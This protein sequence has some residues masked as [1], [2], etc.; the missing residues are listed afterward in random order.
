MSMSCR[1]CGKNIDS[2]AARCK[3]CGAP[4]EEASAG[5]AADAEASDEALREGLALFRQNSIEAALSAFEKA[6]ALNPGNSNAMTNCGLC[7]ASL[8]KKEKAVESYRKALELDPRNTAALNN[9]AE[10]FSES[11]NHEEALRYYDRA[12]AVRS[13]D[14]MLWGNKGTCLIYL[15]RYE[16]A[17]AAAERA[18]SLNRESGT[19]WHIKALALD[20]LNRAEESCTAYEKFL[21][22]AN[23][24]NMED[25]ERAEHAKKRIAFLQG[26][27]ALTRA[28]ADRLIEEGK[29]A[30]DSDMERA[31]ECFH[32]VTVLAPSDG[33]GWAGKAQVLQA[34]GRGEEALP[35]YDM[36][37]AL[38]PG[39]AG[40]WHMKADCLESMS[41]LQEALACYDRALEV[42]P[43]F[44]NA[45]CD[46][47]HCLNRMDR[48][49]EALACFDKALEIDNRLHVAWFNKAEQQLKLGRMDDAKRSY[50]RFMA[51]VPPGNDRLLQHAQKRI[52]QL[53]AAAISESYDALVDRG[54]ELTG[55]GSFEEA[56]FC[57]EKAGRLNPYSGRLW[58]YEGI[59]EERLGRQERAR[60]LFQRAVDAFGMEFS[61]HSPPPPIAEEIALARKKAQGA[62]LPDGA[63]EGESALRSAENGEEEVEIFDDDRD[64]LLA[65][66]LPRKVTRGAFRDTGLLVV[67]A[68]QQ[69]EISWSDILYVY[70]GRVE[71]GASEEVKG[72]VG[73]LGLGSGAPKLA[74]RGERFQAESAH[75]AFYLLDIYAS[76]QI[77]PYRID[78]VGTSLK[79][80]LGEEAG[81]S[82]ELNLFSFARK[83][84]PMVSAQADPSLLQFVE[85]G[86]K[87][88]PVHRSK[89]SFGK[90]SF[91][92][93]K[94]RRK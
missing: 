66:P 87:A 42:D 22:L 34:L 81:F 53:G 58:L 9:S 37:I 69:R 33:G 57:F 64:T 43:C 28:R 84:A 23:S 48:T 71:P 1:S 40:A 4:A 20:A 72:K 90:A 54:K 62:P 18:L 78:P 67:T 77:P 29:L 15:K 76:G 41:L 88:V 94:A 39:W 80:F 92:G 32:Q 14:A 59:L 16:E 85:K 89:D 51:A 52:Y 11:G 63:G 82:A 10:Y 25:A 73:S 21:S 26:P 50:G 2:G 38:K 55:D 44:A 3:W 36:V 27:D 12:I 8:G 31:L 13:G 79:G 46:K 86:R 60:E 68:E 56:E 75:S 70:M 5:K 83:I 17:L 24:M 91:E 7:F 49:E 93:Y 74:G 65:V 6:L 47:G 30:L 45:W 19:S 61:K 35:C